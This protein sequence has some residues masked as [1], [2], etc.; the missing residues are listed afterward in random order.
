MNVHLV[1]LI[2]Y[3]VALVAVGL[4]MARLVKGSTDFF[5]AG[6]RLGAP[7]LFATVLAA[8]IG[9]GTTVGTAG[10]AY[11]DGLSA[12]WWN[13]SAAIGSLVLALW[14]G[15]RVWR[16]AIAHNLYTTG[17]YLELR[18]GSTVRGIVVS[19][20]WI[21]ALSVLAA[22][23]IAGA[24]VLTVVADI[25]RWAGTLASALVMTVYFMAGGLLSSAWVNAVQLVVLLGG[26]LVAAPIVVW[27]VGGLS[28]LAAPAAAHA[29]F[30]NVLYTAGAGSGFALLALLG[31][32]FIVS[33][34]LLQKVYGA[35]S[36]R[37]IRVGIG[38]QAAV[39]A[40]FSFLPVTLGMAA[41]VAHPGMASQNLVLPTV[42]VEQL[43]AAVG[44]LALAA[45]YS[46]EVSTCDAI[47]FM[48]ATSLSQDLY[49]RFLRPQAT[50]QQLLR[51]SRGASVVG[52]IGGVILALQLPT[53]TDALGIFYSLLGVSL[54]VPVI[55]G[56]VSSRAGSP[57][58]LASI[59]AGIITRLS[60]VYGTGGRGFGWIDPTLAGIAAGAL[61]FT[62]LFV[63]RNARTPVGAIGATRD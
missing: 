34:G 20:I 63:V 4:W 19:I 12:W 47:L 30:S 29:D 39:I 27:R 38:A 24:A 25:P 22:Q 16:V 21:G 62:L 31:P 35:S 9:A 61:A 17:D 44:A 7:L 14:V 52:G 45:I 59:A 60:V 48:L 46:A 33:P 50:D 10:L 57:E 43:P 23:L 49:K 1:F 56:L 58:A 28:A 51:V 36:E 13:G 15:P 3:S 6:R 55:G 5:V 54:F 37:A 42:L 32:N 53:I 8:N 18:Y 26:F 40:L 2:V 11:R 41:Q